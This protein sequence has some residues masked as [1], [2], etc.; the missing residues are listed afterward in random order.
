MIFNIFR[1]NKITILLLA[2]FVSSSALAQTELPQNAQLVYTSNLNIPA[3]MS[4]TQNNGQYTLETSINVPFYQ[5]QFKSSGKIINNELKPALF[6]DKRKGKLYSQAT[7]NYAN[8]QVE[9]GKANDYESVPLNN[10]SMDLF[11][12]VWQIGLNKNALNQNIQLTN[13]KSLYNNL[14][15][16]QDKTSS[17]FQFGENTYDIKTYSIRQDDKVY[18]YAIIPELYN[19]PAIIQFADHDGKNYELKLK[20]A[21]INGQKY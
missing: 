15:V 18:T 16:I 13:G 1:N 17:T 5:M 2:L 9:F 14:R 8:Q 20:S 7:F 6:V 10:Y 3:Q 19:I 21:I 11:S 4:L 12:F